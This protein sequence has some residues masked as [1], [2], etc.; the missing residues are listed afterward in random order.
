MTKHKTYI[1]SSHYKNDEEHI[2]VKSLTIEEYRLEHNGDIPIYRSNFKRIS[3]K[4]K[5]YK[6]YNIKY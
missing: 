2:E 6:G 1:K 5:R 3:K 4:G